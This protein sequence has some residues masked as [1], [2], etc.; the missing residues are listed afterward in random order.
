MYADLSGVIPREPVASMPTHLHWLIGEG[1][2][3]GDTFPPA[4]MC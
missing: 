2:G 3:G 1:G 4:I